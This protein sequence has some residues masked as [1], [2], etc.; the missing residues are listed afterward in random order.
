VKP[1]LKTKY[2]ILYH[3][4]NIPVM[5]SLKS[6]SI[7]IIITSP[8]YN[9]KGGNI[10]ETTGI[11]RNVPLKDGYDGFN[12]DLPP[13]KYLQKQRIFI[14]ACW[15]LLKE[16]GAIFYNHKPIPTNMVL[17]LPLDNIPP[18]LIKK[19]LRQIIIVDRRSGHNYAPTHYC[20]NHE[21]IVLLAKKKFSLISR[22]ISKIGDVWHIPPAIYNE[23]PAPFH[24][25]LVENVLN[26]VDKAPVLDPHM[27]SGTVAFVCERFKRKWVGIEQSE[28]YCEKIAIGC[29]RMKQ[30]LRPYVKEQKDDNS[31]LFGDLE[32][33][34]TE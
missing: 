17:R 2:G 29:D 30:G 7:G 22:S 21:W 33:N 5:R 20:P 18:E 24:E 12:D 15:R 31:L 4:A 27:G 3:G 23:H 34:M 14:N 10:S 28:K 16:D 25:R 1:Y 32:W 11:W 13:R 9:L 6:E 26:T 8:P 19:Y